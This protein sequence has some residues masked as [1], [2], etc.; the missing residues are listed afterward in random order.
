MKPHILF[1]FT[2]TALLVIGTCNTLADFSVRGLTR[3]AVKTAADEV[4]K[5]ADTTAAADESDAI[6]TDTLVKRAGTELRAAQNKMFSGKKDEADEQL[7]NVRSLLDQIAS[8]DPENKNLTSLNTRYNRLR[9]DLDKRMGKTE[10]TAVTASA[11]EEESATKPERSSRTARSDRSIAKAP[12]AGKTASAKSSSGKLPYHAREK[13]RAFD[14]QYRSVEYLLRKMEEAKEGDTTTPPEKYAEG[15]EKALPELQAILD[16][17]K[18]EAGDHPDITAAQER[19]DSIPEKLAAVS[20]DV[21]AAQEKRAT[22]STEIAKDTEALK[23]EYERLNTKIFS[24]ATGTSLYYNDLKPVY[25]LLAIIEDYEKNDKAKAEELLESFS[26]KYGSTRDEV[27]ESTDDSQA[28]WDFDNFKKGVENV[29]KTRIAMAEDMV[30]KVVQKCEGLTSLHDFY[31][32]EQHDLIKEWSATAEK[33]AADNEKVIEVKAS[34]EKT[35]ADDVVKLREK[36]AAKKW[37]EHA[38]NA[39][40]DAKKL[41][42]AALEWFK[43]APGWGTKEKE[44][45]PYDILAVSITGPWS[46]QEKN[47]LGEPIVYGLPVKVAVQQKADKERGMARVFILTLRTFEERDAKKAPPFDY[48]TVGDSYFILAENV[49]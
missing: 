5:A 42:K 21:K 44:K 34:L 17:A 30:K 33:F 15:V 11:T 4:S 7:K 48:P 22:A 3:K 10:E 24:K 47:I 9:K 45:E 28:G 19:L 13:M 43:N 41:A 6:D 18:V 20:G 29:D 46:V 23:K 12:V 8:A 32:I 37:P 2:L 35:L 27:T 26:E 16:E 49:K 25:E 14:N 36:I 40:K 1:T 38:A 39:P 31:R